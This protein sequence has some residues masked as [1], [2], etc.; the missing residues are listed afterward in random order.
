MHCLSRSYS[1]SKQPPPLA[2]DVESVDA[3]LPAPSAD[4]NRPKARPAKRT[5]VVDSDV[6]LIEPSVKAQGKRKVSREESADDE[7]PAT[8]KPKRPR[9]KKAMAAPKKEK[10]SKKTVPEV[11]A[12]KQKI[13]AESSKAKKSNSVANGDSAAEDEQDPAPKKKKRK[14]NVGIF[15]S[16]QQQPPQFHWDQVGYIKFG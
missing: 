15:P 6:E 5:E 4:R 11:G 7:R 3:R 13:T 16:T 9:A 2:S 10:A 14:L 12:K 1:Q 8:E